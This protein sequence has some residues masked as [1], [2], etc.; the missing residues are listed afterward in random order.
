MAASSTLESRVRRL[1]NPRPQKGVAGLMVL[2]S[3]ILT[4]ATLLPM[5]GSG[6]IASVPV[7]RDEV[8]LRWAAD[9]FPGEMLTSD[10]NGR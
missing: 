5:L 8:Q 4:L 3:L 10:V 9:P 1:L 6:K 7:S 2:S